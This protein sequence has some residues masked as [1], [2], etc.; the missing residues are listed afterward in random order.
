M[1]CR[2]RS[3]QPHGVQLPAHALQGE[4]PR[5]ARPPARRRARP[6]DAPSDEPQDPESRGVVHL[7]ERHAL[8][9]RADAPVESRGHLPAAHRV[10][11]GRRGVPEPL[12]EVCEDRHCDVR[13]AA[14]RHHAGAVRRRLFRRDAPQLRALLAAPVPHAAEAHERRH[15]LHPAA[16]A[17]R[18]AGGPFAE[19]LSRAECVRVEEQGR[20]RGPAGG[21]WGWGVPRLQAV[22]VQAET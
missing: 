10:Q 1:A 4:R 20:R 2:H 11:D 18:G 5:Q 6:P 13:A 15:V 12:H 7:P 21:R 16:R 22:R 14:P 19:R 9:F 17:Q 8:R 3:Q